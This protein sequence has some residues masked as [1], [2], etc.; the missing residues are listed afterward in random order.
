MASSKII[1]ER[2]AGEI[3]WVRLSIPGES[4][5]TTVDE[6]IDSLPVSPWAF[7]TIDVRKPMNTFGGNRY[8]M[9]GWKGGT[10]YSFFIIMGFTGLWYATRSKS[11]D[12]TS[13]IVR[14]V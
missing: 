8:M 5:F 12:V 2:F 10:V 3:N 7:F 9:M 11:E 4:S 1:N 6:I 14:L 13:V